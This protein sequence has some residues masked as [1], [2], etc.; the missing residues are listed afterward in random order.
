MIQKRTDGSKD[1][2]TRPWPGV[3]GRDIRKGKRKQTL[4]FIPWNQNEINAI[5][6][7][8]NKACNDLWNLQAYK[9]RT[10]TDS[11]AKSIQMQKEILKSVAWKN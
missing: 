10:N 4:E 2:L 7:V 11:Y 9:F 8:L 1:F 5:K 3:N 6:E